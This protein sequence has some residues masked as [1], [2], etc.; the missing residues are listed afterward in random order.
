MTR[1]SRL[2]VFQAILNTGLVPLF[3]TDDC[4]VAERITV[5]CAQGGAIAIEFRHRRP[6]AFEVFSELAKRVARSSAPVI[7]GV[8]SV[9]DAPTAALYL[10][11]GAGFVVSPILNQD[12]TRLCNRQK[13]AC[14]PGCATAT[15]ISE[16][17]ALGAEICKVFPGSEVGGPGFLKS[18]LAP[19]PWTR[20]MP[21][22]GV[23]ATQES[24]SAWIQAG[25]ACLGMGSR[26]ITDEMQQG[27]RIETLPGKVEQ[28]L[29]WIQAA[30]AELG[31]E[32][33]KALPPALGEAVVILDQ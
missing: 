26:L 4:D 31:Q 27:E 24:V 10:A 22:G 9:V 18:V 13:V 11:A 7:L 23:E 6:R 16:A 2:E 21:T 17:E 1:I 32:G 3:D 30:R 33:S 20:L 12:I 25:A 19:M 29:A 14:I 28:L 5:A 8:G 15:E